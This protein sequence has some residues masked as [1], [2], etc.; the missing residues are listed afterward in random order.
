[1][2]RAFQWDLARQVERLDWLMA[3][4]PK[5]SEWGYEE[6]YLHLEDAVDY[7]SLPGVARADAFSWA[8]LQELVSAANDHGIKVVP[9]ANL[10]GHTQYLIKTPEWR[11]LNEL[12]QPDGSASPQGQICP[13]H[14]R[15]GEVIARLF[16]DLTPLCTAGKI[17]VGLDESF[18][19]GKHP[20]SREEIGALGL[21]GYFA[22]YVH[23]LNDTARDRGLQLGI[24]ADMLILLRDAVAK[25]PSGIAAYDWYYHGFSQLPRF[26]L[27]NFSTYD[28]HPSLSAQGIDYWSCPMNGAFRHEPLPIFGDRLANAVAWWRRSHTI[29]A[30]GFLVTS[31]EPIHLCPELTTLVDAAIAGLWLD[32]GSED[33]ATLLQRGMQRLGV[34]SKQAARETRIMLAADDRAFAGYAKAERNTTWSTS[35]FDEGVKP[36][37]VEESFFS[38][39]CERSQWPP[40]R[41]SLKWRNYLAARE[42][43]VR[44]CARGVLRA[45]RLLIRDKRDAFGAALVAL[46]ELTTAFS[47]ELDAASAIEREMW[48]ISRDARTSG[49]NAQILITDQERLEKW[50]HWLTAVQADPAH[51]TRENPMVGEWQL[52]LT[53]HATRPNAN[54]V[55]V[56]QQLP[57]GTWQD[58]HQ[59]HTIEFQSFVA[60][61]RSEFKR[62]WSL[63]LTDSSSP[64]RL[65]LRGQGEVSISHVRITNGVHELRNQ[66]W[67][68]ATRRRLGR[69]AVT[70]GWPEL[71]WTRNLAELELEFPRID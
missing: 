39:A 65:A 9:I 34:P 43:F 26:E 49:A 59:R 41:I 8:E 21:D 6:L 32:D 20:D 53:V 69:D 56:Q 23:R 45:R 47:Q 44:R 68:F 15:V 48:S 61:R 4:L 37:T 19:L 46:E 27:Y 35:P 71:D 3:Q 36:A 29:N 60:K 25:L 5:Y 24:W 50:K 33:H 18:H 70:E 57:D 28:L 14:P 63:P 10:L 31:W 7:P 2:I 40:L 17:H 16:E 42:T 22:R 51:V 12:R 66:S 52:L 58:L 38:R 64:I 54:M 67:P 55:V 11:D 13:S 62:A 1:M 30:T